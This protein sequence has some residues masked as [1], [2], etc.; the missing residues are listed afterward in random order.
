MFAGVIEGDTPKIYFADSQEF[1]ES[2]NYILSRYLEK[3]IKNIVILSCKTQSESVIFKYLNDEDLYQFRNRIIFFSTCRKFKGLEADVV[4]L[5]DVGKST[6]LNDGKL[7]YVGASRA[8]LFLDV[9]INMTDEDCSEVLTAY[10][11]TR[12]SKNIKKTFAAAINAGYE[13]I[14]Y[15]I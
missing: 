7:F 6:F 3:I 11:D 8:R 14:K 5:I 2:L 1:I 4:I 9:I 10:N 15:K 12:R 13:K